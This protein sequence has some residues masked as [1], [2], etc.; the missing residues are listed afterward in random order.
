MNST[1]S[2]SA[3][4]VTS[5]KFFNDS[6]YQQQ[7][8]QHRLPYTHHQHMATQINSQYPTIVMPS[9]LRLQEIIGCLLYYARG[10][11]IT[12]LTAVNHLASRQ[13]NPTHDTMAAAHRLLAY[14]ARY[15]N[16]FIRYD[17]C[18]MILYIQSDASY[19][20][21]PGARSV[22]GGI[23]CMGNCNQPT[24]TNGAI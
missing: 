9:L 17:A 12:I 6:L 21:R 10:V 8:V 24:T 3:C 7:E 1:Q 13:A 22:A 2:T 19:L 23:L 18:D 16:N 20:S 15:P 14:C 5:T 11:D 4:P